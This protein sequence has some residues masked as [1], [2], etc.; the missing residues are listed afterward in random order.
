MQSTA[1]VVREQGAPE[2]MRAEQRD[3]PSEVGPGEAL[4]EVAYAGVN[5]IDV[6]QREGRYKLELPFVPGNEGSGRVVA[7]GADVT[8]V[9]VGDRVA[10]E[11][12][13]GSYTRH[14]VVPVARLLPVADGV[15]DAQAAAL[16]LQGL[17]AH[18]L[19]TESHPI[20]AGETVLIHAG[21]GGTGLVLT[22]V[23]KILGATVITTVS[24]E[25]KAAISREA[26][27]DHVLLGYD[28]FTARVRDLTGGRGVDAVYDG[29]GK[30]TFEG[31]LAALR[32]RGTFVLFGGSSGAVPPVDPM[33]LSAAG[34]VKFTRPT[35]KDF[36]AERAELLSRYR[37]LLDWASQGR[38][39]VRVHDEY[40]LADAAQAHRDLEARKTTGKVLLRCS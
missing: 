35:L 16:P 14:A 13:L 28:D 11:G 30:T 8:D 1:I 5:F 34:S 19:A 32:P 10:W 22:Q 40:P 20:A 7:V 27:A 36:V 38:L 26:G 15:S 33:H 4:V 18:Y 31:S 24:S 25:E 17:T 2:V 21:A 12:V 37:D 39:T 29:V 3:V 9:K 6:Y 23:A